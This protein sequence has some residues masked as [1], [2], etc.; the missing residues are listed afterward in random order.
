[1]SILH[2]NLCSYQMIP[3]I[4]NKKMIRCQWHRTEGSL[5]SHN[6]HSKHPE[7]T[8]STRRHSPNQTTAVQNDL[9]LHQL[10]SIVWRAI[11]W[12]RMT[13]TRYHPISFVFFFILKHRCP[14]HKSHLIAVI[15]PQS[16][17]SWACDLTNTQLL[18]HPT[19][20]AATE[21]LLV[22]LNMFPILT[23]VDFHLRLSQ[24]KHRNLYFFFSFV[25]IFSSGKHWEKYKPGKQKTMFFSFFLFPFSAVCLHQFCLS[26]SFSAYLLDVSRDV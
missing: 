20:P 21:I 25:R 2:L 13:H 9:R 15:S 5:A 10:S 26:P 8:L 12:K 19:P 7:H 16:L 24:G 11:I 4:K 6:W 18:P 22:W 23:I 14:R 17:N 3:K 1:M